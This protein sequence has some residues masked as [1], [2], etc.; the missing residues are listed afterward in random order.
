MGGLVTA[1]T[2]AFRKPNVDRI[3]LSGALLE[4]GGAS[5]SL[6][7][8]LGLSAARILSTMTPRVALST[9]LDTRG[10]SRDPEV[11]RRYERD[12]FV[13]DRMS[14]RFA[15]GMSSMV[16]AIHGAADRIERPILVLHG[17]ADPISPVSGSRRLHA[18]LHPEIAASSALKVYP[19][20]RHEI[21]QEPERHLVW[22]DMLGWLD[23]D[24]VGTE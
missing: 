5:G 10:L 19:A 9:G 8:K 1:A 16:S 20:L 6:R 23:G 13:K 24:P 17:G 14:V 21:F 7:Q 4:L 12:P 18:G 3:V 2:A 22:Q 11:V 15:A